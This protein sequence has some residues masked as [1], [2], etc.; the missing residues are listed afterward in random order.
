MMRAPLFVKGTAQTVCALIKS[1]GLRMLL[2]VAAKQAFYS[3]P[4]LMGLSK[5]VRKK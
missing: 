3:V 5:L 4:F 2:S 1:D